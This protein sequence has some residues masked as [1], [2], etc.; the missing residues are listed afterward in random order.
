MDLPVC[1][2]ACLHLPTV[3]FA[4]PCNMFTTSSHLIEFNSPNYFLSSAVGDSLGHRLSGTKQLQHGTNP[5]PCHKESP[6]TTLRKVCVWEGNTGDARCGRVG[7]WGPGPGRRYS[8]K[9][10]HSLVLLWSSLKNFYMTASLGIYVCM[11]HKPM[12]AIRRGSLEIFTLQIKKITFI[13]FWFTLSRWWVENCCK[14]ICYFYWYPYF[15]SKIKAVVDI[16]RCLCVPHSCI[17]PLALVAK[18]H[19]IN[20]TRVLA[21]FFEI[22]WIYCEKIKRSLSIWF[23][24]M[25]C[26][27]SGAVQQSDIQL[28]RGWCGA[29]LLHHQQGLWTHLSQEGPQDGERRLL[30]CKNSQHLC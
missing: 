15:V 1:T 27:A 17:V 21:W 18:E 24:Q 10:D 12:K 26:L 7:S 5:S 13:F 4:P 30:Q 23:W 19:Y 22:R 11:A 6:R 25:S 14:I 20:E 8:S 9:P 29:E 2:C 3:R 28:D 16:I